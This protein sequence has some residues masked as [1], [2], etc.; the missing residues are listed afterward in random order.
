M[1]ICGDIGWCYKMPI[2]TYEERVK[3]YRINNPDCS[4]CLSNTKYGIVDRVP[5]CKARQMCC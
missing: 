1:N 3:E 5:E 4:Y 2:E